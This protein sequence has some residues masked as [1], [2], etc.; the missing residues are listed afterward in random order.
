MLTTDEAQANASDPLFSSPDLVPRS[1]ESKRLS[2]YYSLL[3]LYLLFSQLQ[4]VCRDSWCDMFPLHY[5]GNSTLCYCLSYSNSLSL[6]SY[7]DWQDRRWTNPCV[8]ACTIFCFSVYRSNYFCVSWIRDAIPAVIRN[9][10][11]YPEAMLWKSREPSWT[12]ML[13]WKSLNASKISQSLQ[14]RQLNELQNP[15]LH[16]EELEDS[17]NQ[18]LVDEAA[19][20]LPSPKDPSD[21]DRDN[22]SNARDEVSDPDK[23]NS[24]NVAVDLGNGK[25]SNVEAE[26]SE[27]SNDESQVLTVCFV[28]P[29]FCEFKVKMLFN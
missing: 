22:S 28:L 24:I 19:L 11:W 6:A 23:D 17:E 4:F 27:V 18:S 1:A 12:N 7:W 25:A 10:R 5:W 9:L 13:R 29:D 2:C 15:N 21:S 8:V 14:Q 16:E 20:E 3:S 26:P